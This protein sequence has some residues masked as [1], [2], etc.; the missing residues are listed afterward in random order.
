TDLGTRYDGDLEALTADDQ[1]PTR[2]E[3]RAAAWGD[4]PGYA[5][6]GLGTEYDGDLEALTADDPTL[7]TGEDHARDSE[8]DQGEAPQA[9]QADALSG[10]AAQPDDG[11]ADPDTTPEAGLNEL[12]AEYE[13]SFKELKAEHETSFK[14][15]K[16]ELAA[17][18]DS[19]E[20][21]PDALGNTGTEA[22]QPYA[23][24]RE[25]TTA[26]ADARGAKPEGDRPGFWSNAK[27]TLYGTVG[28]TVTLV[29]AD[30]FFP[31][32][33]HTVVDLATGAMMIAAA[34]VPV[35]REG[36]KRKHDDSKG[37]P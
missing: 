12:K 31:G 6:A 36:W 14:E 21:P 33:P 20:T 32:T 28:S 8:G 29:S 26:Q 35:L 9:G 4:S 11:H 10:Q 13:A 27:S 25:L 19:R 3:S 18:K 15:L 7:D 16:A 17:L 2:Q 30:R 5:E 37:K 23:G 34:L 22:Q 1:L 24:D